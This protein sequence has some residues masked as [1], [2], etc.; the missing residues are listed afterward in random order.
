MDTEITV[1]LIG[2]AGVAGTI[3]GTVLGA[4]IQARGGHAQAQAA[5]DAAQTA[6]EAARSVAVRDRRWSALTSYLQAASE[7]VEASDRMY[8]SPSGQQE[9]MNAYHEFGL[10]HAETELAVPTSM[11]EEFTAMS[12]AVRQVYHTARMMSGA[13]QAQG[14]LDAL[15]Q[16]GDEAATRAKTVLTALRSSR[17]PLWNPLLSAPAPPEYTEAIEA[18]NA[19]PTLDRDQVRHL[20]STAGA[21]GEYETAR[22]NM[23][24]GRE[25]RHTRRNRYLETRGKLVEAAREAL[26]TNFP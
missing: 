10:A 14:A 23:W 24:S 11:R 16:A 3:A 18:L 12:G 9:F 2:V 4:R 26:G 22:D 13:S 25:A 17:P 5:R 8:R 19:V 7:V 20:L 1:A 6:A 21:P 15:C